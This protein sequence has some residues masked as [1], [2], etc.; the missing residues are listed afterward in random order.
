M[1][2]MRLPC[3]GFKGKKIKLAGS[4]GGGGG[5]NYAQFTPGNYYLLETAQAQKSN[6]VLTGWFGGYNG[7]TNTYTAHS[8]IKNRVSM[9]GLQLRFYWNQVETSKGVYNFTRIGKFLDDLA[10]TTRSGTNK[11]LILLFSVSIGDGHAADSLHV[12]PNYMLSV[13]ADKQGPGSD[14]V[15]Y[16]GGQWGYDGAGSDGYRVRIANNNVLARLNLMLEAL[17]DYLRAHP[18]Y[19]VLESIAFSESSIG[20]VAAGWT[21]PNEQTTLENT[22]AAAMNLDAAL[23]ERMIHMMVNYPKSNDANPDR[24]DPIIDAMEANNLGF[25]SPNVF[26]DDNGLWS[27]ANSNDNGAGAMTQMASFQGA[28]LASLQGQDQWCTVFPASGDPTVCPAP[29]HRPTFTEHWNNLQS[30]L[31]PHYIIWQRAP[32]T[33]PNNPSQKLYESLLAFMNTTRTTNTTR[34]TKWKTY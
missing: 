14:G 28:R 6:N 32:Q 4:G 12:V 16:D 18:N 9:T 22:L 34:P 26:W 10:N 1:A 31:N 15:D 23:P 19:S 13:T 7:D 30:R 27:T 24:I 17:A 3:F 8:E 21:A 20:N 2:Y 29:G 33:D 25:G 5:T 11:K